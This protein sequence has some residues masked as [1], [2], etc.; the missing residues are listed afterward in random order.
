MKNN[1]QQ[2]LLEQ[3]D[4]KIQ[5][6]KELKTI[7]TPTKGWINTFR[8]AIKMSL[9]QL[10]NRL[11]IAPQSVKQIEEREANGT[12]TLK[13]LREQAVEQRTKYATNLKEHA[14]L[15]QKLVTETLAK[16]IGELRS[17]RTASRVAI[18]QL[19]EFALRKLTG[20]LTELHEDHK[21]LVDLKMDMFKSNL[22][23][24]Y[25]IKLPTKFDDENEEFF[26]HVSIKTGTPQE[27]I[28]E[29]F[30]RYKSFTKNIIVET[31]EMLAFN[32]RIEEFY[33]TSR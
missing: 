29:I 21:K 25:N 12:I 4:K 1:K 17:D 8:T 30:F 23:E 6:F 7:R 19:E 27:L 22:R 5:V 26:K 32:Q 11:Q 2:L 15:L 9:R 16:E 31:P 20:E 28:Q 13:S 24:K 18:G 14:A 33:T 10:G 3:T